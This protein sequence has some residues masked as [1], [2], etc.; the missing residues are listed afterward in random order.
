MGKF[1]AALLV[2]AACMGAFS[3]LADEQAHKV[4]KP[5]TPDVESSLAKTQS[6][7]DA[8]IKAAAEHDLVSVK[9]QSS[10]K[11][12]GNGAKFLTNAGDSVKGYKNCASSS[13]FSFPEGTN[14]TDYDELVKLRNAI[15]T[16]P[17]EFDLEVTK[18]LVIS[19][20][21]LG[22]G[23]EAL[24]F[25]GY[26]KGKERDTLIA[27]AR[28]VDGL[29]L[30][31]DVKL[32]A[33]E[34]K[35]FQGE[36]DAVA[37][38][39]RFADMQDNTKASFHELTLSERKV[40]KSF[41]VFLAAAMRERFGVSA[42]KH[43]ELTE[44][45]ALLRALKKANGTE[46]PFGDEA[47]LFKALY[48][49]AKYE[50]GGVQ[51]LEQ[52]AQKE[53]LVQARALK[54]LSEVQP[55]GVTYDGYE[56]DLNALIHIYEGR[57]EARQALA[58][59]V[60]LH[61]VSGGVAEALSFI[62]ADMNPKGAHFQTSIALLGEQ[63][64]TQLLGKNDKLRLK[65]LSVL[66]GDLELF[67]ALP[68]SFI[69]KQAGVS[70]SLKLGLADLT[71]HLLSKSEW[72]EL[73]A[74][75]LNSLALALPKNMRAKLPARAFKNED[76][77]VSEIKVAFNSNR[78]KRAMEV[79]RKFPNKTDAL[80]ATADH[81][82]KGGYWGLARN[83]INDLAVEGEAPSVKARLA[84]SLSVPSPLLN[85]SKRSRGIGELKALQ[86]FI[87]EDIAIIKG[88]VNGG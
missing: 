16:G 42:V 38:W 19:Y 88:Y 28:V 72:A 76:F 44:A 35:C 45:K 41:P 57:S 56:Q 82:W 23:E 50:A 26:L 86:S 37:L 40:I 49:H 66:I 39:A 54:H 11:S 30:D 24:L 21:G 71:P 79:L 15:V 20:I 59:K 65:A 2:G 14:V 75:L 84:A 22:F 6:R 60:A 34:N 4:E 12:A 10:K 83:A 73:D 3:A 31:K 85:A 70:A 18:K 52:L 62:K 47:V 67:N 74:E 58:Q 27:M 68:D 53:G 1:A 32:L 77:R 9:G 87:D 13:I 69:L 17:D 51:M 36:N 48:K 33:A 80:Q 43:G 5:V 8:L 55:K 7:L 46:R 61:A 78:P 63:M 64:Q 25:A 29:A 81:A